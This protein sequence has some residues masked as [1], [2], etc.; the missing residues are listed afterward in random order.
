MK[1]ITCPVLKWQYMYMDWWIIILEAYVLF[2][3][4]HRSGYTKGLDEMR[5]EMD[6][7]I[8]TGQLQDRR[9]DYD[10]YLEE[11]EDD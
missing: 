10:D 4:G 7:M 11:N 8:E 3:I 6:T 1:N 5:D 2:V 9:T